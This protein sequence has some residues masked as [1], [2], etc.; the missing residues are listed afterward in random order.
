MIKKNLLRGMVILGVLSVSA[1]LSA[2]YIDDAAELIVNEELTERDLIKDFSS[3]EIAEIRGRVKELKLKNLRAQKKDEE[4][5][6]RNK[7]LEELRR[8][9]E[10]K[11]AIILDDIER[12]VNNRFSKLESRISDLE[13]NKNKAAQSKNTSNKVTTSVSKKVSKKE[14]IDLILRGKLG[15]GPERIEKLKKLGYRFLIITNQAG[16]ARGYYTEE[17]YLKLEKF[18]TE[19]LKNKGIKIEKTYYCPHHPE[20]KGNYRMEC[21]CRKPNTGNFLKA[22]EEFQIDVK[23]SFMVGD[24][25]T[26]LIPAEKLEKLERVIVFGDINITVH[27]IQELLKRGIPVTFLSKVGEYFGSLEATNNVDIKRQRLQFEKSGNKDFCLAMSKI[28]I[29][30]KINN[31]RA[32]LFK[33]NRIAK[34]LL[35]AISAVRIKEFVKKVN[36]AKNIEELNTIIEEMNELYFTGLSSFLGDEYNFTKRVKMPPTDP[37]NSILS[38]GYTLLLYEIKN[39]LNS[40]GLNTYAGF[41]TSDES[42]MPALCADLMEEWRSIL[43]DSLAFK[44]LYTKKLTLKDFETNGETGAVL[45]KKEA[46]FAFIEEFEKLLRMEVGKII[47]GSS[48]L[49]Y[50]QAIEYQIV[51]LLKAMEN[52]SPKDYIPFEIDL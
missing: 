52:N 8:K 32:F 22:I 33:E 15:D 51:L 4:E 50:R 12:K 10:G 35:P 41:F 48:K 23:K 37:F 20:G 21:E 7:R 16:I 30:G 38:F 27:C 24:R 2:N 36:N 44:L 1:G 3:K 11:N 45:L 18:I 14:A 17:D 47:A 26:D 43:V 42:S 40:K 25:I 6:E 29:K 46:S 49:S 28:F 9:Q 5:K 31:Q 13:R 34:E 39:M 19:D